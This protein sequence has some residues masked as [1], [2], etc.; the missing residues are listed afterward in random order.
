MKGLHI[1]LVI[2]LDRHEA[3]RWRCHGL[4][5]CF[6]I[7]E[8][9][10][11]RLHVGLDIL[12]RHQSH[13][14]PLFVQCPAEEMRAA[15]GFHAN[16]IDVQVRGKLQQLL[17]RKLLAHHGFAAQV[18]SNQMKDCLAKVDADRV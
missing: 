12:G 6:G 4:S 10:L 2:G 15:T 8:V 14:V 7:D 16:Q 1:Q 13:L 18:H 5:D 11:V 3:H 9:A 17:A